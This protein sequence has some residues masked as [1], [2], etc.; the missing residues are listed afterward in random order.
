MIELSAVSL[1]AG[2]PDKELAAIGRSLTEIRQPAGRQVVMAGATGAAFLVILEGEAEVELPGGGRR[3]LRPGDY[4][5]E[6]ALIDEAGRSATVT[7]KS[8]L[9]LLGMS[10]WEF[11]PF[12]GEHPEVAWRLLTTLTRRLREAETKLDSTG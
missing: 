12:V 6:M 11:K 2:L 4:Y 5:G 3:T 10:K 8:D 7:A 9:R 1:F